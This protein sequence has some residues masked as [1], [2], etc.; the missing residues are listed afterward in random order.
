M[1]WLIPILCRDLL[2]LESQLPFFILDISFD[3]SNPVSGGA[4]AKGRDPFG[5]LALKFF[6]LVL[7]IPSEILKQ[8]MY[9]SSFENLL[10]LFHSSY[11]HQIKIKLNYPRQSWWQK[12]GRTCVCCL[13]N[14]IAIAKCSSSHT[15]SLPVSKLPIHLSRI[16][17][18]PRVQDAPNL[19]FINFQRIQGVLEIPAITIDDP[20]STVFINCV[21]LEQCHAHWRPYNF[22]FSAYIAFVSCLVNSVKNVTL[23]CNAG[24]IT[25]C[26]QDDYQAANQF[27][28]LGKNVM[29]QVRECYLSDE[30]RDVDAYNNGLWATMMCR[31][32]NSSWALSSVFL[33]LIFLALVG[34][35]T[36][37][38]ILNY[39]HQ[40]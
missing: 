22:I 19:M 26:S 23:L 12:I 9:F 4:G 40:R 10:H 11:R 24:I 14:C 17:L 35:Q 33:A 7:P 27:K 32:F 29:F 34:I 37:I 16:K 38:A 39:L 20:T 31:Y 6:N 18:R 8:K 30:F 13:E 25:S 1:P 15:Q 3:L 28:K 36:I 2:K 5:S 21:A